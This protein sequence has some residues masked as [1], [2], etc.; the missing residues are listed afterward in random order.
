MNILVTGGA[1]YKGLALTRALLELGHQVTILDNFMYGYDAAL[2]LFR[3]P[4][5]DFV[6]RDLRNLGKR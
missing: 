2:F 1:G 6:K 3:Y 5:V 4:K